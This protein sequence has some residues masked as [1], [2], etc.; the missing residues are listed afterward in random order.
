MEPLRDERPSPMHFDASVELGRCPESVEIARGV[1]WIGAL[2]PA[3]R[4]FD[5]IGESDKS[6]TVFYLSA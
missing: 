4:T 6:L 1:Q 5:K 2:D 3:L